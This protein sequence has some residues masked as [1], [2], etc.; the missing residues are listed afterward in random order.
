MAPAPSAAEAAP[1][2]DAAPNVG[3]HPRQSPIYHAHHSDRY[4]RQELI[5]AYEERTGAKLLAVV[6]VIDLDFV[7]NIE[8]HLINDD[9]RRELHIVLRSPGGDGE[10]ALRAVRA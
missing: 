8:E 9:G 7:Q 4:Q 1:G 3:E 10:Q 6:D 5:R 2:L